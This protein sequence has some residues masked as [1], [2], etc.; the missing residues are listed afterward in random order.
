MLV[1]GQKKILPIPVCGHLLIGRNV[2][3]NGIAPRILMPKNKTRIKIR[4]LYRTLTLVNPDMS[5]S[6]LVQEVVDNLA[7]FFNVSK[8]AAKIRMIDLGFESSN[9]CL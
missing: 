1:A 9:R 7:D 2:H 3:A 4:E 8:Q 5:R 6:E